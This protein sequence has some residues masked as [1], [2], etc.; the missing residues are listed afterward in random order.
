MKNSVW[1]FKGILHRPVLR[2]RLKPSLQTALRPC[3]AWI[4]GST[5]FRKK[6]R[7]GR[8]PKIRRGDLQSPFGW[9]EEVEFMR[10]PENIHELVSRLSIRIRRL[11]TAAP[12]R[13]ASFVSV[14]LFAQRPARPCSKSS[15]ECGRSRRGDLHYGLP[16]GIPNPLCP[17]NSRKFA[18][19]R[20]R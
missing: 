18:L 14:I 19:F 1:K 11:Q 16:V 2:K 5:L 8:Q 12:C 4:A 13:K 17:S 3:Y 9:L 6:L 20:C 7:T 10:I 15:G